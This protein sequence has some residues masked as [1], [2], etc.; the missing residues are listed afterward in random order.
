ML[1]KL[2]VDHLPLKQGGTEDRY[3]KFPYLEK[4]AYGARPKDFKSWNVD[5][6]KILDAFV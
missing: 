4:D 5:I 3:K 6:E 2:D 1:L